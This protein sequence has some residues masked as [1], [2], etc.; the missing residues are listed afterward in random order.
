MTRDSLTT[1]LKLCTEFYDLD[2]PHDEQGQE[3][4]FYARYCKQ[5]CGPILEPMCGS[6]RF[7]IPLLQAG[8]EIEGF[9]ASVHMLDALR[10]KYERLYGASA[11]PPVSHAFV[12]DFSSEKCYELIF[13]PFGSFG[14]IIDRLDALKS[15][16]VLYRHLMSGGI[17]VLEIETLASYS[18]AASP[19][20]YG[21]HTRADG[22]QIVLNAH[23]SYDESAQLY[24][25]ACCYELV[26]DGSVQQRE[27]EFFKQHLYRFDEM[28]ELLAHFPFSRV[29]KYQNFEKGE[30][31][32]K[33]S[34]LLIYEC[35]K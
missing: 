27:T 33:G 25:A 1:Y 11:K 12:Q 35:I 31:Q 3:F 10:Y 16:E 17:L 24:E 20:R 19:W 34:P 15:L 32:D 28:D 5:A 21:V 2:K 29:K 14:L 8:F 6:G 22:A 9:D 13:I 18:L 7:L 30:A 26:V 4:Q 23:V